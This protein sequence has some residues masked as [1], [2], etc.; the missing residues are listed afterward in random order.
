M[1]PSTPH[2]L[3]PG[4]MR[5]AITAQPG[6]ANRPGG[7]RSPRAFTLIELLVVILIIA[8]LATLPLPA[9]SKTKL[10]AM[11]ASCMSNSRQLMSAYGMYAHDNNDIALPDYF[12]NS[13][14]AWCNGS[15]TTASQ[16]T[17]TNGENLIK[18]SP[19][20]RYL[21]SLN[22]FRCPSDFSGLSVGGRVLLRNRS[23]S[24]N[25][26]FGNSSWHSANRPPYKN[27]I[28]LGDVTAPGPSQVY[29]IVEEHENSINDA[30]FYPFVNMK[31]FQNH[32]WVDAPSGRHGNATVFAFVDGHVEQHQWR[33]SNVTPVRYSGG[34]VVPNS[35]TFLPTPGPADFGW[36]TNHIAP[37]Q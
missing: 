33:D 27:V 32:P 15:L 8:I 16:A 35:V 29:V 6:T 22:V 1:N 14:P 10:K 7:W 30:H 34:V 26:A 25:G 37:W 28:H 3:P 21:N 17:G 19:T 31:I 12:Y 36:L 5:P 2:G 20:Y 18:S 23:Y 11:G 9:L 24:I 13:V 4:F